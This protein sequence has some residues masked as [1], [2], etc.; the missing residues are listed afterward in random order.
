MIKF[1]LKLFRKSPEYFTRKTVIAK[2]ECSGKE[3]RFKVHNENQIWLRWIYGPFPL[4]MKN[5]GTLICKFKGIR[6]YNKP[7]L[8]WAWRPDDHSTQCPDAE[9]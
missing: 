6:G 4:E 8:G 9:F 7:Y 2:N 3:Y 5:D 1:L